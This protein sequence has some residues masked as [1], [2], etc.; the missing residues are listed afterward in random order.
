MSSAAISDDGKCWRR[1]RRSSPRG[2]PAQRGAIEQE[3][4]GVAD[5]RATP[6]SGRG[7]GKFLLGLN[8]STLRGH[9][10][11]I[12]EEIAIA[13]KAGYRGMEPWVEELEQPCRVGEVARRRGQAVSRCRHLR[14][15][16][17]RILR[18]DRG[19]SGPTD[20]GA[21]AGQAE[22]GT[23]REGRRQT[24][25]G[26]T[27]RGDESTHA[28]PSSSGRALPRLAG[29][30]RP[31]RESSRKSRSGASRGPWADWERR[32]SSP[33]RPSS[34]GLHPPGRVS[35]VSRRLG[36]GRSQAPRARAIHVFHFN[37]YPAESAP[38]EAE[39]RTSGLSRRRCRAAQS[40]CS[41]T[42][43]RA[44]SRSCCRWSCSTGSTGR[45]IPL[46]SRGRDS[47]R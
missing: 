11:S 7:S 40:A 30:R 6:R 5:G 20:E 44:G 10:L 43:T 42:W 13:D 3:P 26:T 36:A 15:E 27:G 35:P 38:G 29:A 4:Q 9:K 12:V 21:G 22:H 23:G 25:R 37:D 18:M 14:R 2:L 45:R 32:H 28:G 31:D 33:W 1:G 24:P 19:R 8:T 39:R 41:A 16:R 34:V 17:D 46:P 47:R